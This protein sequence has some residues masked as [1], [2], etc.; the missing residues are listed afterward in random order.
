MA[1]GGLENRDDRPQPFSMEDRL[2]AV[3]RNELKRIW[4]LMSEDGWPSYSP[5]GDPDVQRWL[6]AQQEREARASGVAPDLGLIRYRIVAQRTDPEHPGA[7]RLT[8]YAYGRSVEE[9]LTKVRKALEKPDGLYGDQGLYRVVEVVEESPES[10]VRQQEEARRRYLTSILENVTATVRGREPEAPDA[11]LVSRLDDFFTRAVT[12]PNPHTPGVHPRPHQAT[13]GWTSEQPYIEHASDPG[14]ALAL[15]L[16]AYL[17]HYG[18]TLETA[19]RAGD[20][21]VPSPVSEGRPSREAEG[22]EAPAELVERVLDVCGQHYAAVTG[23]SSDQWDQESSREVVSL[24]LR[25]VR[26]AERDAYPQTLE[27]YLHERRARLER[28]WQR[29]GPDGMFAGEL[30][31]IDLPGCFALCERIDEAPL[32]LEGM[33]SQEGQEETALERLHHNWLYDT[34]DKDGGR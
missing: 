31:L 32:W 12:F 18:L 20:Q 22:G 19:V 25:T 17:D 28:L 2:A 24:A 5:D 11:D 6:Q 1:A 16:L 3:R 9:A 23:T 14:R 21:S 8:N 34:S 10:E 30:V 33:W 26:M 13:F 27:T 4:T 7:V 15:F 29:Y